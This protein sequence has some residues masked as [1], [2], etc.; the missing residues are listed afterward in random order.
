M[1]NGTDIC[2]KHIFKKEKNPKYKIQHSVFIWEGKD[3]VKI[4]KRDT[5]KFKNNEVNNKSV[6]SHSYHILL[7]LRNILKYFKN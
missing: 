3:V 2:G 6:W 5:G 1:Y 7:Y 4:R